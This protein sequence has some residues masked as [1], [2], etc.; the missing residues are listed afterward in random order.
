MWQSPDPI[1]EKY[2]P[3]FRKGGELV[4]GIAGGVLEPTNLA[5]YTYARQNP[6]RLVDPDGRWPTVIHE[7]IIDRA[8]PGLT[9]AQRQILKDRSAWVDRPAGQTKA[10]NHEHAMK[11]PGEDPV[12]ARRAIDENIKNHE[13]AATKKQGG[14]PDSVS[15]IK[16]N[17]LKEFGEA[18]HPVSDRTSPAHTDAQNNPRDWSGIPTSESEYQAAKQHEREEST[19]SPAQMDTAAGA[20][21]ESFKRTFGEK[22]LKE[23]ATTPPGQE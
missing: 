10:H 23:A 1:L 4:P 7:Q 17:A 2:L 11:S 15:K 9:N 8:F 6:L 5:L 21:R 18:L 13:E 19:I 16:K 12:S 3:T 14:T 22:A 20:A